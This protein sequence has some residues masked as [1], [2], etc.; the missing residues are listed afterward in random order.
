MKIHNCNQQNHCFSSSV[1]DTKSN[2]SGIISWLQTYVNNCVYHFTQGQ[3]PR[4]WQK[5]DRFGSPYWYAHDPITGRS[6]KSVTKDEVLVWLES[7]LYR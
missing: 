3:E 7:V 5:R 4:I 2:S 1:T 6:I